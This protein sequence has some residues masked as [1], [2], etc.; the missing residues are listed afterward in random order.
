M[1][2][3]GA[4]SFALIAV[5]ALA[6][7]GGYIAGVVRQRNKRR[8]RGYFLLG[9]MAGFM[10]ASVVRHRLGRTALGRLVLPQRL[11]N[12]LTVAALQLRRG[13]S[14]SGITR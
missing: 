5:A 1:D 12:P 14:R 4:L 7:L 11:D 3:V 9:V 10:G 13:L 8:V 2:A 6:A